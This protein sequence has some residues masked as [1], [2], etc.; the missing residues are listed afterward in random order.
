MNSKLLILTAAIGLLLTTSRGNAYDAIITEGHV[1]IGLE[2]SSGAW[3]LHVHDEE[4]VAEYAPSDALLFAD[5]NTKM[6]RPAGAQWDFLGTTPGSD[7]WVLPIAQEPAK[8]FLG[9][10]AEE[11]A[12]G[13]FSTYTETDPRKSGQTSEWIKLTLQ[14]VR[15]PGQVSLW[16]SDTFG[17]P[18]VWWSTSAGGI[19]STDVVFGSSGNHAHYNFGFTAPGIYEVDVVASA[20]LG[21]GE[22]NLTSSPVETYHFGIETVPEPSSILLGAIGAAFIGLRRKRRA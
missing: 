3:N 21:P 22:T 1:D 2:Y 18:R 8:L 5:T 16:D 15:G 7:L 13:S 11:T 17:S 10:G 12:P 4:N 9:L 6:T 20:Y 19:T 14:A